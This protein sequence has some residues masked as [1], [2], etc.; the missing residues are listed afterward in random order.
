MKMPG[1][2]VA[3]I[4]ALA[5]A[6]AAHALPTFAEV[7]AAHRPSDVTLLDRHG[8]PIQTLRVDKNVRR[9]AWVPLAEM[10]PALLQAVVLSEDRHFYE[11]SGV[12]WG[13]VARSAWGNVWN[14]KTRGASTL[15]MQL[16]GLI[17]DGLARP[18][19]GRSATQK[20]GQVVTAAQ[21]EA[22]WKKSEI[23]EAYLNSVTYRGEIVG[24]D[25]LAQTLFGKHA[26]GLDRHEAAIAA[27][28]VRGPNAKADVVAQRACGVLRLQAA[29]PTSDAGGCTGVTALTETALARKGGM[30][31]G[32]QLAPHFARLAIASDDPPAARQQRSTLD[33]RL[34]R[35]SV[36]QLR[37]QL[38]E[39]AD[40]NVEDGAVV[41]LDNRSGE[42]LA[43]VGSSGDLSGAAQ[44]DGVLAR[45]QPGSTLKPFVYGLAFERRLVT[46]AS[47]IDDSPAQIA[48]TNGLYLP[49]NYD[50][51]FKG[52]VSARTALGASLNVP[53][54]RI[55]AMLGPDALVERFNAL[56]LALPQSGGFYG[57]ALALGAADVSLLALT[58]AYRTLANGGLYSP[59]SQ[60][61][62]R[63]Q[64]RVADAR[65]VFLVTH[66]L[67]DNNARART[68]GLTSLLATRGFAAVKTGTSKDMRDNWC[69]GFTDR[70]TVGVWIGNASGA[71]MHGVSG[72]S[73]AAPVWQAIVN[74]LHEGMPS[75][76][77]APPAGVVATRVAFDAQR[78][79]A[80]DEWF[81][82][83]TEQARQ[84]ASAQLDAPQR[85]GITSPRDGSVFAIDPD[86]PGAV[87][88]ITF[89][90]EHGTWVLDG[91]R[92]GAAQRLAWAP[93][94]GR[95]EL[96]L[97]AR[98]GR[99]LQTVRFEVRGAGLKPR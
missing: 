44:V 81:I 42:V 38:A 18:S 76:P 79:P 20:L 65:A 64:V 25:A 21:L 23:L 51:D 94:P 48:T 59:P 27:A 63:A 62:A 7:R 45:R 29:A 50:H 10:S 87:Q 46:P 69:V 86:M 30:P 91:K 13:A 96:A 11:H 73:G 1:V 22:R 32:E 60:G 8:E 90:G 92:L 78:E 17:D 67:A 52:W 71:A 33:A 58:N 16:A 35:F 47:L 4:A 53:A 93:W 57:N 98:D 54:V 26:S 3:L 39:L 61:R 84:R 40:R 55:G 77:P 89:E 36:T 31:L 70:Y 2:T 99:T 24:I 74:R 19:G 5:L 97:L 75:T 82:A 43:W 83:G 72:V 68:F 95:H 56:G 34:Q 14:T 12:D 41:V 85:L 6:P 9:L 28:L 80:R 37:R 66:I 49:Q 15:T 88:R